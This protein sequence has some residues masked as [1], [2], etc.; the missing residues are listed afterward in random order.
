MKARKYSPNPGDRQDKDPEILLSGAKIGVV[1][2]PQCPSIK[3]AK[4]MEI[5]FI[6]VLH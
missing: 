6:K 1:L 5:L 4:Q 2:I 3:L